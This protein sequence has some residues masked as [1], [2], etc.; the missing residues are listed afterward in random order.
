MNTKN[1]ET[2]F[3]QNRKFGFWQ[4]VELRHCGPQY[5]WHSRSKKSRTNIRWD[6]LGTFG[7]RGFGS[8]TGNFYGKWIKL[9]SEQEKSN[10]VAVEVALTWVCVSRC[11]RSCMNGIIDATITR[12]RKKHGL[13]YGLKRLCVARSNAL[14]LFHIGIY[15]CLGYH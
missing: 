8:P 13:S 5:R 9:A 1:L 14:S 2:H 10:L 12:S 4:V 6:T 7:S 11:V 15:I 3:Q